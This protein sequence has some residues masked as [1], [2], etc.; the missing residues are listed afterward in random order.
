MARLTDRPTN[1]DS[2]IHLHMLYMQ[3]MELTVG[4]TI[5][6]TFRD[7][8]HVVRDRQAGV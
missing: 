3:Y 4:G 1:T 6:S 8:I 7:L 5:I 2:H